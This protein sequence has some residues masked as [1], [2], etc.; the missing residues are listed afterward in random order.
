MRSGKFKFSAALVLAALC[1]LLA[2]LPHD[3]ESSHEV[4]FS[5]E[6][7]EAEARAKV[8]A[9]FKKSCSTSGCHSGAYPKAK[10]NLEPEK[11][12]KALVDAPSMKVE[13]F[14][15]VDTSNPWKSYVLMKIRGDE[16]IAGKRM[17]IQSAPLSKDNE[18]YIS[19]WIYCVHLVSEPE[20]KKKETEKM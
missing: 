2:G 10:L 20:T 16:G 17:P 12:A 6:R 1:L 15:L 13:P 19:L 8:A 5:L 4:E 9:I 14:K 7:V 18:K 11:F 3:L